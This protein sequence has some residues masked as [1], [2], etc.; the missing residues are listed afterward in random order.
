MTTSNRTHMPS[1]RMT[2][3]ALHGDVAEQAGQRRPHE[4]LT[5]FGLAAMEV[6]S[7]VA[8]EVLFLPR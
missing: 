3:G 4:F 7:G 5:R 1:M 6:G 2:S 8:S